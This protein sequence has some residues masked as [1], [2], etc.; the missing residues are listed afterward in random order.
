MYEWQVKILDRGY[1]FTHDVYIWRKGM[2]NQ[3]QQVTGNNTIETSEDGEVKE[4]TLRL[5]RE[6]LVAF[7]Q[8][9]NDLKINPKKEFIEGKLEATENHLQDMRKLLKL[10]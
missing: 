4:P 3:I 2:G 5:D 10:N 6:Q 9:L 1:T 7:A 8:A